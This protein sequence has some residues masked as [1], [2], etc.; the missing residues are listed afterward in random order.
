MGKPKGS[1]TYYNLTYNEDIVPEHR[2]L[3]VYERDGHT[4]IGHPDMI[5]ECR[6]CH[7][8]KNQVEFSIEPK[9]DKYGRKNLK[10]ICRDCNGK[11][12]RVT[13][14]LKKKHGPA[15]ANCQIC[16]EPLA[17]GKQINID[18]NHIT[19]EFRGWLCPE[20][21]TGLGRFKDDPFEIIKGIKYLVLNDTMYDRDKVVEGLKQLIEDIK[22]D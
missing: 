17:T 20:H 22:N 16:L 19:G 14:E 5:C 21:N 2:K 7:E 1:Y 10:T 9:P 3:A 15:P 13:Y 8:H 12:S 18:H 11:A 4:L 6:E